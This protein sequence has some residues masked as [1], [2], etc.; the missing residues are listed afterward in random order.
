MPNATQVALD[1][2]IPRILNTLEK[3]SKLAD[4]WMGY[5]LDANAVQT[6]SRQLWELLGGAVKDDRR[7]AL[8]HYLQQF[9]NLPF[10]SVRDSIGTVLAGWKSPFLA[11]IRFVP[12]FP[13]SPPSFSMFFIHDLHRIPGVKPLYMTVLRGF[14]GNTS[15]MH[16]QFVLSGPFLQRIVR[17]VGGNRYGK[18]L[19]QD[20]GG[21]YFTALPVMGNRGHTELQEVCCSS[22]AEQHNRAILKARKQLCPWFK[23]PCTDC[24]I[25]RDSCSVSR[26]AHTYPYSRCICTEPEE[27]EG[28]LVVSGLCMECLKKGK[29]PPILLRQEE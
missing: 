12:W 1:D 11:G 19:D 10:E 9:Q 21:M 17:Q 28:Y 4:N 18:Y 20:A 6:L 29:R 24:P 22:S 2:S 7:T 5:I 13:S 25:G 14:S 16:L 3:Y 15:G 23:V 26:H 8:V 27:H